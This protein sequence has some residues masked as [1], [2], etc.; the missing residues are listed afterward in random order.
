[1]EVH[2]PR[3][4]IGGDAAAGADAS[5]LAVSPRTSN[6]GA[7]PFIDPPSHRVTPVYHEPH[8]GVGHDCASSR[9]GPLRTAT[10][11]FAARRGNSTDV[12]V[13][14]NTGLAARPGAQP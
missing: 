11:R 8:D 1:L 2:G 10:W 12:N 14:V 3:A 4:P 13:A 9:Q 7:N 5:W 6:A